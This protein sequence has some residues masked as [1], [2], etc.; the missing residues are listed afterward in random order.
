MRFSKPA[1]TFIACSVLGL[2]A[3]LT[4]PD[5][6]RAQDAILGQLTAFGFNFCPRGWA[7]ANGALLPISSNT[8]LFSLLG[9]QFG[10]NG[11]TTFALPDLRGRSPINQGTGPGLTNYPMGAI[12]GSETVTL[13]VNQ[14]P[15][16]SHIVNG[17]NE[18]ADK[19]GP[20]NDFPAAPYLPDGSEFNIYH[21]GP[22][23]RT[24]DPGVISPTGGSQPH[25]NR[26][27]FVAV[28]WC[29]ATQGIYP[30]RS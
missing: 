5:T 8:A 10:G 4:V 17:T 29:I 21:D 22:P 1:R 16:H 12:G 26:M 2:G 30:S 3:A 23:N 25:E 9:T 13:T 18:A 14:M 7:P 11:T 6:A 20:G 28:N 15:S 19:H 27:P 24:M